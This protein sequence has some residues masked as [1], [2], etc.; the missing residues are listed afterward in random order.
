MRP[1]SLWYVIATILRETE[2]F[3]ELVGRF[4]RKKT[5]A[6]WSLVPPK[7]VTPSKLSQHHES[8][9]LQSFL[10]YGICFDTQ[11]V[12]SVVVNQGKGGNRVKEEGEEEE[13]GLERGWLV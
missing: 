12:D 3:C 10:L 7:D 8:F 6:D 11:S 5:F 9:L 2:N 4:S 1:S 13:K